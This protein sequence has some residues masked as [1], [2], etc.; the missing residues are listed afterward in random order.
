MQLSLA[1][2]EIERGNICMVPVQVYGKYSGHI[3][4]RAAGIL[5]F[6]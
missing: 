2:R 6:G 1:E 4:N 5:F 3:G